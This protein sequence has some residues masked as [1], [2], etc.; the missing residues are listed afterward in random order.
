VYEQIRRAIK[1]GSLREEP[2][3]D[4]VLDDELLSGTHAV[5]VSIR[6]RR[7]GWLVPDGDLPR[8]F[9]VFEL[10]S[11]L[12]GG[13]ATPVIPLSDDGRVDLLYRH[14]LRGQPIDEV[15]GIDLEAF[16]PDDLIIDPPPP[17]PWHR[18]ELAAMLLDQ[19]SPPT[20]TVPVLDVSDPWRHLYAASLGYLPEVPSAEV[21]ARARLRPDLTWDLL[22]SV[23]RV[24]VRGSAADLV[25]R[26]SGHERLYPR[27]ASMA[28]LA[29][30]Y[31]P[32][33]SI[34]A[35]LREAFALP[36][37]NFDRR[38]AGPNILVLCS[39]SSVSD[40]ALVWNLRSA[41]G[42]NFVLPLGLLA[43]EFEP[44]LLDSILSDTSLSRHGIADKAVYVTSTS[45]D[46]S[47]LEALLPADASWRGEVRV[48]PPEL[49]FSLGPSATRA[50]TEVISWKEG[51]STVVPISTDERSALT[52]RGR[53][54]W[55]DLDLRMDVHVPDSPLPLSDTLR[56]SSVGRDLFHGSLTTPTND[57]IKERDVPWPSRMLMLRAVCDARD[58]KVA[59]SEPGVA[60]TTFLESLGHGVFDIDLLAH[61]PLID[62]LEGMAQRQGTAWAKA[63][64]RRRGQADDVKA[65]APHEDELP[66]IDFSRFQSVLG[67]T[68]AAR[69]WLAWAE[70]HQAV[71]KGF[72]VVCE[73]C[74]AKQWI[75]VGGFSPPLT[76]RGCARTIDR[77][78][79]RE[80]VTFKYRLGEALRRVY[81]HDAIAH[82]LTMRYMARLFGRHS[83]LL[84]SHPGLD[85]SR[86][87][88]ERVGEADVLILLGSGHCIPVEVKRSFAGVTPG[89]VSRLDELA[90]AL[91]APW[92]VVAVPQWADEAPDAFSRL[93]VRD[94]REPHRV[95]L[96]LEHLTDP[97]VFWGLGQDPFLH[98]PFSAEQKAE[99]SERFSKALATLGNSAHH[100]W[101]EVELEVRDQRA[102]PGSSSA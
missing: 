74:K 39:A 21:L 82:L 47:S 54:G 4:L 45:I 97:R 5:Q 20:I 42:D 98:Q 86:R 22:A 14:V 44:P 95:L 32:D 77:P 79:P 76:C 12:W 24:H 66:E 18:D 13:G 68:K 23:E 58:L 57:G 101:M 35:G 100:N 1:D 91:E 78:F 15:R 69:A 16:D 73:K 25:G 62:L 48:V 55:M 40:A 99:R 36:P 46:V 33:R 7:T 67:G 65:V 72:P 64:L 43:Q 53:N 10:G 60:C 2:L 85:I 93:R 70:S 41:H 94:G 17:F 56:F 6:P 84:G 83:R 63:H 19:D 26:T 71:L 61:A 81:E 28:K 87:F 49:V 38:D 11:Q 89:E 37:S 51:H 80:T 3:V 50:R 52:Y 92:S 34:R 75:P 27:A 59:P 90:S 88:G 30:G 9:D 96:T 31:Q 102:Q 8:L 29:Y